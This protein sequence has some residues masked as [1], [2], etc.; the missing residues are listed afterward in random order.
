MDNRLV[1]FVRELYFDMQTVE[2]VKPLEIW[3]GLREKTGPLGDGVPGEEPPED[4]HPAGQRELLGEGIQRAFAARADDP[5]RRSCSG[6]TKTP[7]S[8]CS[9]AFPIPRRGTETRRSCT[10]WCATPRAHGWQRSSWRRTGRK[11]R[12][13]RARPRESFPTASSISR[14]MRIVDN[15]LPFIIFTEKEFRVIHGMAIVYMWLIDADSIFLDAL[16]RNGV[17]RRVHR[18]VPAASR[19]ACSPR[20]R[21][22]SRARAWM[23]RHW[24]G[25]SRRSSS[26][27]TTSTCS[28]TSTGGSSRPGRSTPPERSCPAPR[29]AARAGSRLYPTF[30]RSFSAFRICLLPGTRSLRACR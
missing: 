13:R 16:D 11:R 6:S 21:S 5:R 2:G 15:E 7:S 10:A 14:E 26:T 30:G 28:R 29:G 1:Q 9:S 22:R 4:R 20:A 19:A 12:P 18:R 25:T 27:R 24:S 17:D 8:G 3:N 23:R